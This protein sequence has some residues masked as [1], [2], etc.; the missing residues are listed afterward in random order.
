MKLLPDEFKTY[1][2][3]KIKEAIANGAK[4][5]PGVKIEQKIINQSR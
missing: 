3:K 4:E 1:D 5:I 2:E